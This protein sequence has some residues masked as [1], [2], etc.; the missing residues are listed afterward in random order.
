MTNMSTI[1]QKIE[2]YREE[3][4]ALSHLKFH[5]TATQHFAEESLRMFNPSLYPETCKSVLSFVPYLGV[6]GKLYLQ[7]RIVKLLVGQAPAF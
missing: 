7:N 6:I 5:I 2:K 4:I 1:V 3:F